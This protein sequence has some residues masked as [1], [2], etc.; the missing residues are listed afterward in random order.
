MNLILYGFPGA[1]K[2]HYGKLLAQ[3]L[4]CPFIDLDE[5]ISPSRPARELFR[6]IGEEEFRKLERQ[7]LFR[8]H[9]RQDSI[10]ALGGGTVLDPKNVTLL[11]ALGRFVYFCISK[12]SLIKKALAKDLLAFAAEPSPIVSL[13]Q[14]Y[15]T[16]LP[17]YEAI[18]SDKI[19]LDGQSEAG[20]LSSLRAIWDDMHK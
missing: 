19:A 13:E 2:S 18:F 10:I 6:A 4:H 9:P 7:A 15:A 1:G 20:V 8:L 17:I 3:K 14:E 12:E 11:K 5:L 16:R